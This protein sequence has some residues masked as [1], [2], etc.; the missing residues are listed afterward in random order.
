M[1]AKQL[2]LKTTNLD[3]FYSQQSTPLF[4]EITN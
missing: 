1:L 3:A 2:L 4:K